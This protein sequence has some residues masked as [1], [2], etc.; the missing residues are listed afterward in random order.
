[1]LY[2]KRFY[3]Q[4]KLTFHITLTVLLFITSNVYRKKCFLTSNGIAATINEYDNSKE[5]FIYQ[6]LW[7]SNKNKLRIVKKSLLIL[8]LSGDIE[9]NPGPDVCLQCKKTIR[10]NQ[11]TA[12]CLHCHIDAHLRCAQTKNNLPVQQWICP[13]CLHLELPFWNVN[14]AFFISQDENNVGEHL[15]Q[16]TDE[17]ID[18]N[19]QAL[20]SYRHRTSIALINTQSMLSTFPELEIL[21]EEFKFDVICI[22]ETWLKTK[23]QEKYVEIPAYN[24]VCKNRSLVKGGGVGIYVN[25]KL[26]FKERHDIVKIND[27][28]EHHWI[29][30]KGKNKNSSY[31]VG[32]MYQPSSNEDDKRIW[33]EKFEHVLSQISITWDGP[34]YVTGDFNIDLRKNNESCQRYKQILNNFNLTQ[35]ITA[36]TR[37]R[38][39]LIDHISSNLPG[40]VLHQNVMYTDE[41]SDHDLAYIITNIKKQ[42]FEPRYKLIRNQKNLNINNYIN[43]FSQLPLNLVYSFDDPNEQI[44]IFNDIVTSCMDSHAPVTRTKFTRP[45]APWMKDQ[46]IVETRDRL[47]H[48]RRNRNLDRDT[49][50]YKT[51]RNKYKKLIR[52]KKSEFIRKKLSSKNPK[53]IWSTIHRILDPPSQRINQ[54]PL[55]LR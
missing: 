21:L 48:F 47:K 39:S 26:S 46:E 24:F 20:N 50:N 49:T 30:I 12:T 13:D 6:S 55:L 3:R 19:Q 5:T 28:I 22:T 38:R 17:N 32:C 14:D 18:S 44:E 36:A 23:K 37:K 8:L 15:E 51:V 31:L 34:I 2:R 11:R 4:N 1:M 41:I 10:S 25:E 45:P 35:H 27:S 40:R 29:E 9:L 16:A 42:R 52:K 43:D 54:D 53:E 33:L 7:N